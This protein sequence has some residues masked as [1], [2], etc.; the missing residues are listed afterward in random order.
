MNNFK[1]TN[2]QRFNIFSSYFSV[3]FPK[4]NPNLRP[5]EGGFLVKKGTFWRTFIGTFFQK[6]ELSAPVLAREGLKL[7]LRHV[8]PDRVCHSLTVSLLVCQSSRTQFGL[9]V[10]CHIGHIMLCF[11][12]MV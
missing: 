12:I 6:H 2:K 1:Q 5:F 9:K 11:D 8:A 10:F 3:N 7:L 4:K